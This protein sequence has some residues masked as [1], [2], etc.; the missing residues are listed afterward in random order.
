[1]SG[2]EEHR[3]EIGIDFPGATERRFRSGR[4]AI[5]E[6][7]IMHRSLSRMRALLRGIGS[8][9]GDVHE[10]LLLFEQGFQ[11]D[12]LAGVGDD[13]DFANRLID[14][15]SASFHEDDKQLASLM[16]NRY[17]YVWVEGEQIDEPAAEADRWRQLFARE[18]SLDARA[19]HVPKLMELI[20]DVSLRVQLSE[21][22]AMRPFLTELLA[23][24]EEVARNELGE[25]SAGPPRV[26]TGQRSV[27][28]RLPWLAPF[29]RTRQTAQ[30]NAMPPQQEG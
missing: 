3:P 24:A 12:V 29:R 6:M 28:R 16:L 25:A 21:S 22:G 20:E 19:R 7:V 27:R 1:M 9:F 18:T 11:Q 5:S 14:A 10:G 13:R 17:Q 4:S 8:E 15:L 2:N 26:E 23:V 30:D